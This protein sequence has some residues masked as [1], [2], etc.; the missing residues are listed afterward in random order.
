MHNVQ[1]CDK[2]ELVILVH[3]L[4]AHRV[5]MARLARQLQLA[6]YE[7]INW[8]YPSLFDSIGT[9]AKSLSRLISRCESRGSIRD[10]HLVTHSMGSV[11]ARCALQFRRP[12]KLRR[13]VMLAPPNA[14]SRAARL[15]AGPLGR[16]CPP[17]RELSD[18]PASLVN[19]LKQPTLGEIGIIAAAEDH[20][21]SLDSTHLETETA[22]IQLPGRHGLLPLRRDTCANVLH[23]LLHGDFLPQTRPS[24]FQLVSD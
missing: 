13:I 18:D 20:V 7:V 14:G 16:I 6:G 5:V 10:I 2:S 19:R 1:H 4:A 17:L 21:V 15:L 11:I 22:H 9:H 8:G 24:Q 23:F 3:G 12:P